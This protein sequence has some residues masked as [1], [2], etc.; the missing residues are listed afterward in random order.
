MY[1]TKVF[2][3]MICLTSKN[4]VDTI[5]FV[6][7]VCCEF[8]KWCICSSFIVAALLKFNNNNSW[9]L[10]QVLLLLLI[11]VQGWEVGCWGRII[12]TRGGLLNECCLRKW[13][14]VVRKVGGRGGA[15]ALFRNPT[16][17]LRSYLILNINICN[18]YS[19]S[20][21]H[22]YYIIFLQIFH[23]HNL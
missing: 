4:C 20:C 5:Y 3:S 11:I 6:D 17:F 21:I 7:T 14:V 13:G 2:V 22:I 15:H 16:L 10:K 8:L 19:Y 23:V 12:F 1:H 18:M 9:G